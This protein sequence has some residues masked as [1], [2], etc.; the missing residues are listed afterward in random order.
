[1]APLAL[2]LWSLALA[3]LFWG[4]A[5]LRHG[6]LQS[7]AYDLGLFDQWAW[8]LA[9]G[10]PPISSMEGVHV[11]ADH[12]AWLFPVIALPY[13][14]LASPQWLLASQA[15]ALSLTAVPLWAVA[16]QA[17][18][19]PRL[20]WL[21][22]GLWWL[23]PV[24][25][26]AN[27]FDFH[28][29]VWAMP[30]L[31]GCFWALRARRSGL[32]LALLLVVL[33]CRDGL[34]LVVLGL[35]LGAALERRWRP[36][37]VAGGLGLGWLLLLSRWFYPWLRGEGPKA[38][39]AA[40]G[41]LGG[42]VETIALNLLTRPQLVLQQVSPVD[43]LVYGLL[44]AVAVAPFWRRASLPTLASALPL[45]LS[46]L[47]S[48]TSSQRTLIHHYNLPVAVI[49][50]V[51]AVDGLAVAPPARLPWRRLAWAALCWAA[52]AKPWFFSG[53]YLERVALVRPAAAAIASIS[54]RE[55][56]LTT[57]YLVPQLSRRQRIAFPRPEIATA[58]LERFDVLLLHP[59]D[60]G[61]ASDRPTQ[62]RLLEGA[63]LAGWQCR[64]WGHQG[65]ELCRRPGEPG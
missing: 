51:A 12:A 20:A 50:V 42:S 3:A 29:E 14:L 7:N 9:A 34:A 22:C 52:L 32:W 25:F 56:V 17:G 28:P 10:Q 40:Y 4:A 6:L 2:W 57:S 58:A 27:L 49:V 30:A 55:A 21:V 38:A 5:A 60:P 41:H 45:V 44:L 8:L 62:E 47:I 43:A 48:S 36:A 26:N 19:A 65:L 54:P 64:P 35:G 61:W 53:P 16:R 24:V 18:L 15:L 1:M 31:A 39:A 23:Q 13:R 63:R 37:L 59:D 33:G 46:N 11:L